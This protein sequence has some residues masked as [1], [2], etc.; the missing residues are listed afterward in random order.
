MLEK[1]LLFPIKPGVV[2]AWNARTVVIVGPTDGSSTRIHDVATGEE[3]DVSVDELQGIPAIG[4][5]ESPEQR[6][7]LVR[8]S[9]QAE[10][11]QARRRERV[12]KRCMSEDGDASARVRFA[13]RALGLS[14]RT[15][16]RL[17][18]KYR[19]A[20][21]TSSLIAKH[22]GTPP[23]VRRLTPLEKRLLCVASSSAFSVGPEP[24][25]LWLPRKSKDN[26]GQQV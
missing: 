8:D 13:C 5:I 23:A 9:T 21:Q 12:L 19:A 1:P 4:Q 22:R 6:W 11:K 7:A 26:A 18:A 24:L 15:I 16:Y 17:L 20:A 2:A 10:W 3:R 14:R 25:C